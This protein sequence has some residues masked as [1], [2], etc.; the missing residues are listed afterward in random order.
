[1]TVNMLFLISKDISLF[2]SASM[3]EQNDG[4]G[5][6]KLGWVEDWIGLSWVELGWVRL[7]WKGLGNFKGYSGFPL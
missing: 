1:M 4:E 3:P 6:V 2:H 5:W 7:N